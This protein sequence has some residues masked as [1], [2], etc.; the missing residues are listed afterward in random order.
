ML[1]RSQRHARE[2]DFRFHLVRTRE[3]S[4]AIA[5]QAGEQSELDLHR[6]VLATL[7]AAW[8][9][10]MLAQRRLTVVTTGYSSAAPIAPLLIAAPDYLAGGITLGGVFQA[11]AAFVQVQLALGFFVDNFARLSDWR[12]ALNRIG[13]LDRKSTRLNSSH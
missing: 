11:S 6:G 10:L 9:R 8:Q 7:V 5:L 2:G 13:M 1:F 4:E 12:A 3:R